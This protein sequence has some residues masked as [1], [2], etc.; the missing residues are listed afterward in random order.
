MNISSKYPQKKIGEEAWQLKFLVPST[1]NAALLLHQHITRKLQW[2]QDYLRREG[3]NIESSQVVSESGALSLQSTASARKTH[4][5]KWIASVLLAFFSTEHQIRINIFYAQQPLNIQVCSGNRAQL[6]S[7]FSQCLCWI[8]LNL[9]TRELAWADQPQTSEG[10][11]SRG[12]VSGAGI[13]RT[14][15]R[16]QLQGEA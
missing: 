4:K 11:N 13:Q 12:A 10:K 2:Q 14:E 15:G 16:A 3:R 9:S 1:G 5:Q 7:C 8:F 6:Y